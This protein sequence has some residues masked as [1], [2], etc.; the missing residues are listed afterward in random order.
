MVNLE[1]E[2]HDLFHAVIFSPAL[3]RYDG[4]LGRPLKGNHHLRGLLGWD[5]VNLPEQYEK[6]GVEHFQQKVGFCSS[7]L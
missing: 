7:F 2:S 4:E 6:K 1:K 5:L 3:H